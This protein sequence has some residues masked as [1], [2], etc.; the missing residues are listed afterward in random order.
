MKVETRT[1]ITYNPTNDIEQA[2]FMKVKNTL[3]NANFELVDV[4]KPILG[5]EIE[6]TFK[7]VIN[8][9]EW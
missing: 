7:I 1:V 8:E 3:L 6:V 4:S 2:T 9:D 5:N